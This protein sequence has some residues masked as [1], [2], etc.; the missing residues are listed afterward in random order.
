M[1]KITLYIVIFILNVGLY[2]FSQ[3]VAVFVAFGLM[4]SGNYAAKN[5]YW[6][7]FSFLI[8]HILTLFLGYK[9]KLLINNITMLVSNILLAICLFVYYSI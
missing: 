6:V 9:K 5:D 2:F 3:V 1:K 4:G 7:Y 8:I